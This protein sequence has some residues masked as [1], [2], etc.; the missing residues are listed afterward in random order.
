MTLNDGAGQVT[1]LRVSTNEARTASA[2][3]VFRSCAFRGDQMLLFNI[4]AR[5][6]GRRSVQ[7][8]ST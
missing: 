8:F 4:A 1:V 7:C 2:N 6:A 5:L 3:A